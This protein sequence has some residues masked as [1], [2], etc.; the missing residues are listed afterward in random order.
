VKNGRFYIGSSLDV[1]R[2]FDE[3]CRGKNAS[4][5][6]LRPLEFIFFQEYKD[7][8]EARRIEY[9]LKKLKSRI[10][11]ERIILDNNINLGEPK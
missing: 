5:K 3:H 6:N 8:V 10:I 2:R 9:R 4:T 7:I 1:D 11:I